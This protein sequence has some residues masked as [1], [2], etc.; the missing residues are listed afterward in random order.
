L[1][2]GT[3]GPARPN[4]SLIRL[5]ARAHELQH[6][7][8]NDTNR[9]VLQLGQELDLNRT[10]ATLLLRLSWLAPDITEAILQGMGA[11]AAGRAPPAPVAPDADSN[12]PH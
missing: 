3:G 6:R 8:L 4:A 9:S 11:A 2:A 7:L 5:L 12:P 10:Y 1:G